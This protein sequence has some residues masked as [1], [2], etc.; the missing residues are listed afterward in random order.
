MPLLP[1]LLLAL[2]VSALLAGCFAAASP[3]NDTE[4][5]PR[6]L[7]TTDEIARMDGYES[8]KHLAK[9]RD[10]YLLTLHRVKSREG[11]AK[12][13]PLLLLHGLFSGS[14]GFVLG[15]PGRSAAYVFADAGYDV[16]LG[17][18]RGNFY[19]RRHVSLS[20]AER[21][22]WMFSFQEMGEQDIPAMLDVMFATTAARRTS[23]VCH[24]AGCTALLAMLALPASRHS[25][26][27][28]M[29]AM[30]APAYIP[31]RSIFSN[32]LTPGLVQYVDQHGP[33]E[34][35]PRSRSLLMLL[36]RLCSVH[37]RYLNVCKLIISITTQ[38]EPQDMNNSRL[39]FDIAHLVAGASV[40]STIHFRQL[41][42]SGQFR[43]YDYG[44]EDN[45]KQYGQPEPP[46]FDLSQITAPISIHYG[47][48]DTTVTR[49]EA[50]RLF[51]VL[52]LRIGLFEV[53]DKKFTHVDFLIS[54]NAKEVLYDNLTKIIKSY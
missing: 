3:S 45:M 22:F 48:K 42:K 35:L 34:I 28:R 43:M 27:I 50:E 1:P 30:L 19:S 51:G 13:P 23:V 49:E 25:R 17:N 47:H 38:K 16:W 31:H 40:Y 12:R 39:S 33:Y 2:A 37:S 20:P 11:P 52:P 24:S 18:F 14:D 10:G 32:I 15:G 44:E 36:D 26:A 41:I 53:P 29:A 5:D 6:L 54:D 9:T 7:L 8:E 21:A 46:L 4:I